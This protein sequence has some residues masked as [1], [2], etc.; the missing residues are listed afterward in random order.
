MVST[1]QQRQD[2][3]GKIQHRFTRMIPVWQDSPGLKCLDYSA[4]LDIVRLWSLQRTTKPIEL[5]DVQ[6]FNKDLSQRIN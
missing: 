6:G 2:L 3:V 4:R 1:L 5:Q